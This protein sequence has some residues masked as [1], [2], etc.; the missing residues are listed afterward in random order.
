[1]ERT[2]DAE[3]SRLIP[4]L[5]VSKRAKI[6]GGTRH[7]AGARQSV[8]SPPGARAMANVA[9]CGN[10]ENLAFLTDFVNRCTLKTS[11]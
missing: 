10:D 2:A 4:F 3:E 11:C 7:H 5:V 8:P 1:M 6:R 9:S